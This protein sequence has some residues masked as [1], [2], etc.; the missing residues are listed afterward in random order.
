MS[1]KT[2]LETLSKLRFLAKIRPGEKIDVPSLTMSEDTWRTRFYRTFFSGQSR[3][4][5]YGFLAE[6]FDVADALAKECKTSLNEHS[7]SYF[8]MLLESM[9]AAREGCSNLLNTYNEDRMYVASL[10]T[11]LDTVDVKISALE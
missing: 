9:K 10:Q 8:S 5:T 11:L 2:I 1:Q 4:S 6:T 3:Q 7:L